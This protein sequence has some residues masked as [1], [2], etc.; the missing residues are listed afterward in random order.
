MAKREL[1]YR[2]ATLTREREEGGSVR[3]VTWIP[4]KQDGIEID[5][6]CTMRIKQHGASDFGEHRWTVEA[7]GSERPDEKRVK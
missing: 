3:L 2:Q 5:M 7:I 4:E 6:G 1:F